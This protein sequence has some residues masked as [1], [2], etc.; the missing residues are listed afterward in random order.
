MP[1]KRSHT[2]KLFGGGKGTGMWVDLLH[3]VLFW[4]FKASAAHQSLKAWFR[5]PEPPPS[6]DRPIFYFRRG[7]IMK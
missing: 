5:V 6:V 1:A 3:R 7:S 4:F 2:P